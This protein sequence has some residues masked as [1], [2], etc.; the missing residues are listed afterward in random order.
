VSIGSL[1]NY[2]QD[3]GFSL[4]NLTEIA[5]R[6]LSSGIN[7]PGTAVDMV[8]RISRVLMSDVAHQEPEARYD[9]LYVHPLDRR[10][11][12]MDTMAAIARDAVQH[13]EVISALRGALKPLSGHE[14]PQ[15]A[16]AAQTVLAAIDKADTRDVLDLSV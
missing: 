16:E 1:R 11:L 9:R 13:P 15:I 4:L 2:V 8:R 7:D 12:V 5:Q 14:D 6:A 10:A 3:P